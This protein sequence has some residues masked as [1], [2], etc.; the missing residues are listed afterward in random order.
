M[1][2]VIYSPPRANT[3]DYKGYFKSFAIHADMNSTRSSVAFDESVKSNS[4]RTGM[5]SANSTCD[6][7]TTGA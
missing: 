3:L 2:K 4:G 1:P 6:S 7:I 5:D